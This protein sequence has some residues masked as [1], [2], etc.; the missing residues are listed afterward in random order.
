MSGQTTY[1]GMLGCGTVGQSV[2]QILN[3]NRDF[4]LRKMESDIRIKS[5]CVRDL[6]KDR[7]IDA[8]LFTTDYKQVICDPEITIVVEL[9]GD[10]PDALDA[11]RLALSRGN[12]VVTANK[13]IVARHALELFKLAE[14]NNCELLFEA[15]VAGG[16][17]ILRSIR[18]GLAANHIQSLYGIINGTS[19]YI[20][21]KMTKENAEFDDVL[22]EAQKLGYAEA[23][24]ASDIE[25]EDAAYKLSILAMLCHGKYIKVEDIFCKG[26]S[27]IKPL[28]IKMAARFGYVIKL[29]GISKLQKDSFEARVHPTMIPTS[30]PLAHVHG[31]FNAIQYH[32]DYAG[33]GMLYGLGAGGH[34]TASAVVSDLVELNRNIQSE[35]EINLAPSGFLPKTLEVTKPS[36]ILK[37]KTCYYIRFSVLDRPNVLAKIT[38]ILGKNKISIQNLYQHGEKEDEA[39][40]LIVFTHLTLENDI[41]L[42]LKEIDDMDFITQMTKIIR[43]E[44]D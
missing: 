14:E 40:P 22:S 12:S 32:A 36:D 24:P 16:I 23:D 35:N 9:M 20:L 2:Y 34:P 5:I 21:T 37:L 28:D 42:A 17:P 27:Y 44:D 19:N 15:S 10:C 30:N 43:I 4:F 13:A 41:R 7:G 33:E 38:A 1:I 25:G 31:A 18:E 11:I 6:K 3:G 8:K 26:I 29:L 39:I